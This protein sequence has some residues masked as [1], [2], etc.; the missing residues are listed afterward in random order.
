M[1]KTASIAS[2]GSSL[3][4]YMF[5]SRRRV[6]MSSDGS[7]LLMYSDP[8]LLFSDDNGNS[9][10]FETSMPSQG[11]PYAL[12]INGNDAIAIFNGEAYASSCP[13]GYGQVGLRCQP[14]SLG[15]YKNYQRSLGSN[16]VDSC[17]LCG[18]GNFQ[19]QTGQ[20]SCLTC[21]PGTYN[22]W[23]EAA[24][25]LPCGVG[26]Y[27]DEYGK[28]SCKS[29][30]CQLS[31]GATDCPSTCAASS[32]PTNPI[33]PTS[34]V[35]DSCGSNKSS[36]YVIYYLVALPAF[37]FYCLLHDLPR[38]QEDKSQVE[39]AMIL[40][41]YTIVPAVDSMTDLLYIVLSE[42]TSMTSR[43]FKMAFYF[44]PM[45]HFLV[46]LRRQE[47]SSPWTTDEN[48][49]V[50]AQKSTFQLLLLSMILFIV[51]FVD[52][53]SR[54][55]WLVLGMIMYEYKIFVNPLQQRVWL[56]GWTK[57]D[58]YTNDVYDAPSVDVKLLKESTF[59]SVLLGA[60]PKMIIQ[61]TNNSQL[62]EWTSISYLSMVCS[63]THIIYGVYLFTCLRV[64]DKS[65]DDE[66][67]KDKAEEA[68]SE[69]VIQASS[70]ENKKKKKQYTKTSA[71]ED[72]VIII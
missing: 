62:G 18:P 71:L 68:K 53:F 66:M 49:R 20:S 5:A 51:N 24:F 63:C 55:I 7:K 1:A 45:L 59:V 12:A 67:N 10:T 48:R 44:L 14:C 32:N 54:M 38:S 3:I 41:T 6:A 58:D 19:N 61:Y 25:C 33:N 35:S 47:Y 17:A 40:L 31:M 11:D 56:S 29:C 60:A 13:T 26:S 69:V 36:D 72:G 15:Q 9:W 21:S 34:G 28:T 37:Y 16:N 42:F 30:P 43:A 23:S 22:S 27:Q 50:N 65:L 46:W 52:A 2:F 8:R 70:A 39:T 4:I 64:D 57:H